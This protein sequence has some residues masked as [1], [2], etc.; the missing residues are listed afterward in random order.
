MYFEYII[1]QIS[2]MP[3]LLHLVFFFLFHM[4][5][6]IIFKAKIYE[7]ELYIFKIKDTSFSIAYELK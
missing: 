2:F 5:K 6:N 3:L 7:I 4:V 1:K